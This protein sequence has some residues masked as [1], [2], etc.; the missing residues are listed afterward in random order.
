VKNCRHI[1]DLNSL[2]VIGFNMVQGLCIFCSEHIEV[3]DIQYG[4]ID[5]SISE[6]PKWK[7]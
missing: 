1:P 4:V 5:Y 3:T 6:E 7:S 2:E